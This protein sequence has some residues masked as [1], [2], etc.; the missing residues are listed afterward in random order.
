MH[1][2]QAT[3]ERLVTLFEHRLGG[4]ATDREDARIARHPLDRGLSHVPDAAVEL[5]A[6]VHDPVDR[7]GAERLRS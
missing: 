2:S 1:S 4:A 7:L 6:V 5:D 3:V